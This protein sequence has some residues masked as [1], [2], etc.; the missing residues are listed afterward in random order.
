MVQK[1]IQKCRNMEQE[2]AVWLVAGHFFERCPML[3]EVDIQF[4]DCADKTGKV[5][6][7]L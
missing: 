7:S 3:T 2:G 5:N 6:Q 4:A 1:S